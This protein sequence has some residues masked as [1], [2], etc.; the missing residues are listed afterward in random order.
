MPETLLL[1]MRR[2]DRRQGQNS[3]QRGLGQICLKAQFC[4]GKFTGSK[5]R[6]QRPCCQA[7]WRV[8]TLTLLSQRPESRPHT[9][10][11]RQRSGPPPP[12]GVICHSCHARLLELTLRASGVCL[13]ACRT[14]GEQSGV[15][16]VIDL[17]ISQKCPVSR[18][19]SDASKVCG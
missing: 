3:T 7:D 18:G 16:V 17:W 14:N 19:A 13:N 4:S 2:R 11:T 8:W 10:P 1:L 12:T 15:N 5:R 6:C 9:R